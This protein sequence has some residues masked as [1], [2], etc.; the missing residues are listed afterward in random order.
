MLMYVLVTKPFTDTLAGYYIICNE[1]LTCIFY[2]IIA[3]PYLTIDNISQETVRNQ[4]INIITVALVLSLLANIVTSIS[5]V[6][7]W[8]RERRRKA[9][10]TV[11]P[12][13]DID[14]RV[15]SMVDFENKRNKSK[16]LNQE[17]DPHLVIASQRKIN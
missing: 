5:K 2:I 15:T 11:T 10:Q 7:N 14:Y 1:I 6:V 12:A 3:L 8:I 4:C 9:K 16:P 17:A 13:F